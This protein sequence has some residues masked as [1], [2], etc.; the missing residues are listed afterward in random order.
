MDTTQLDSTVT[1]TE[2]VAGWVDG[3]DPAT[4]VPTCPGWTLTNLV[5]HIGS[6]QRWVTRL[7][8]EGIGDP[9]AAFALASEDAPDDP[10]GW[11]GW[12]RTGAAEVRGTLAGATNGPDVFDPS[13]GGDGVV[14]W[15]RRVFGEISVHRID[16]AATLDRRYTIDAPSAVAA[17]DDWLGTIASAGWAAVVPGFAD[18]MR[19]TG[20]TIAW[21]AED[22]DDAWLLRR[23]DA[24]L[25]LT[26]ERVA[27]AD[28]LI[29]GPA[30]QLLQVV[31]RRL[32]LDAATACTVRG[33]RAELVHLIDHMDWVA[34]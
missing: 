28:V 31:S 1:Q 12:L 17:I 30:E 19:G 32:P 8:A 13:G 34:G 7:V 6:T 5:G 16:A 20:Q 15:S 14:F 24:P 29:T 27:E 21:V 22:V 10:E 11:P 3:A 23:T 26:S 33:D 2:E 4:P 18:A 9:A 25:V